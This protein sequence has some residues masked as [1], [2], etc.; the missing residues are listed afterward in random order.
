[1]ALGE[2]TRTRSTSVSVQ[3]GRRVLHGHDEADSRCLFPA[4][5]RC[6]ITI[7]SGGGGDAKGYGHTQCMLSA[8][9]QRIYSQWQRSRQAR[10]LIGL[11]FTKRQD[12]VMARPEMGSAAAKETTARVRSPRCSSAVVC[13]VPA[14]RLFPLDPTRLSP[15][16]N[17]SQRQHDSTLSDES[18]AARQLDICLCQL[19]CSRHA[20]ASRPPL[21]P[22]SI[23]VMASSC[24]PTRHL[25]PLG[26][27]SDATISQPPRR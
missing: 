16:R 24:T 18:A 2:G 20:D 4:F 15:L 9:S 5:I 13:V 26:P 8:Y 6:D 14:R 21:P 17:R 22:P 3:H 27:R 23:T 25:S 19:L 1:M 12:D 10:E 7:T 11:H